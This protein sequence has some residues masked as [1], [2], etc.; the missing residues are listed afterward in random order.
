MPL[1]SILIGLLCGLVVWG[2]LDRVQPQALRIIFSEELEHRMDQQAIET[3][4]RFE[5]F[6]AAHT[7]TTRLLANHRKLAD[8]LDPIYWFESDHSLPLYYRL[9]PPWMPSPELWQ[10]LVIPS[11]VLLLDGRGR[12]REIYQVGDGILPKELAG[13]N[14][15]FL[16]ENRVQSILTKL[17]ER[18]YLL[19]TEVAE[20]ATG[21]VM[22]KLM[23]VVPID[24]QFLSASQQGVATDGVLVG[25]LDADEQRFLATSRHSQFFT[26]TSIENVEAD[27]LVTAQSFGQYEGSTINLQFATLVPRSVVEETRQRVAGLERRQRL[28]AAVTFVSV[29]TLVFYL[30]S[31]QLNRI[32]H[33]ISGFSRRALGAAQP[34]IERGNQLFVLEDWIGQF[35]QL[36]REARD[37]MRKQHESEMQ[38]SEALKQAILETALDSIVTVDDEGRIIEFNNTA[39]DIF[40]Y[41]RDQVIGHEF[42]HLMLDESSRPLFYQMLN[43][44]IS[45]PGEEARHEMVAIRRDGS[46]FPVELAVKPILLQSRMVFT[47]YMHDISSRRKAEQEI[48]SQ[49]KFASESPSPVLRIN[50]RGVI[51][52]AN[53]ASDPLLR[54]WG[55][56]RA[57]TLP[58]YWSNRVA[59]VSRL[60]QDWET[61]ILCDGH[62][63]SLLMTPVVD[64]GYVNIYGRD[65]TA[66]REAESRAREHQQ[67]LVHVCRLSTMGEMA[68]GL[69]HEL[70]QPLSAIANY[71]NGSIRRLQ[72]SGPEMEDIRYALAQISTQAD[73]A[74]EIIRRM[75]GLVAKQPPIRTVADINEL[76]RE[77]TSFVEFEARKADVVI[78]AELSV[79]P[80]PARIDVV[81]IEQVLLNLVRNALEALLE[82]PVEGRSLVIRTGRGG[83]SVLIQVI[84]SGPGIRDKDMERLFEPFFTT[85]SSGMGMGLV[86]SQTIMEDHSGRIAV[87]RPEGGGTCFTLEL[88]G[89]VELQAL[90]G[91]AQV[92][93]GKE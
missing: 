63:Y 64:L 72:S 22:G 7:S 87:E 65:I 5:N 33:R 79:D 89:A 84:D 36:V 44:G 3:L 88:P 8:Y 53:Q 40:G 26:G 47:V 31:Q 16:G 25:V 90:Y 34:V 24:Q 51:I 43:E 14:E 70:N 4:I 77:V 30:L 46:K 12:T 73:R 6:V 55:C 69:A 93:G 38:E 42:S 58:L 27:F 80:L 56:E 15:L 39:R 60:G 91:Q 57:Q 66:V 54:Y 45:A 50:R 81:Q 10:S 49:A 75:R 28:V 82:I 52:Y 85:K 78:E 9:S 71:S 20:D 86:I 61:Q 29:F 1:M 92:T 74:G 13:N 37:E 17:G 48:R 83:E 35:I 32:L 19:I 67:E 59:E 11:H 2:V 23:L 41:Q 68:T 76:V 62:S 18:P 21:T